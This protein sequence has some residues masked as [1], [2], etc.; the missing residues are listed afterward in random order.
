MW[1]VVAPQSPDASEYLA[2]AV[3]G[4]RVQNRPDATPPA[5]DVSG[6]QALIRVAVDAPRNDDAERLLAHRVLG[7]ELIPSSTPWDNASL[8]HLVRMFAERR[9]PAPEMRYYVIRCVDSATSVAVA[10]VVGGDVE[11]RFA[12]TIVEVGAYVD[13]AG[14]TGSTTIDINKNGTTI[15][16]TKITLETTEKT[17]RTAATP[18]VVSVPSLA[19]GDVLTTDVDGVS[20]TAPKGLTVWLGVLPT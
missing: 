6:T 8:L 9:A 1:R 14:V 19:L 16:S 11:S 3:L 2:H 4:R 20:T 12:G 15:L 5:V 18:P 10:N 17:S 13:T 7:R